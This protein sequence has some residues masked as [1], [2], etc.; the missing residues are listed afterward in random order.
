MSRQIRS[1]RGRTGSWW[2]HRVSHLSRSCSRLLP[3]P[4]SEFMK[5][6][7]LYSDTS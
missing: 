2:H 5:R 4:C 1:D 6:A 3:R 7:T